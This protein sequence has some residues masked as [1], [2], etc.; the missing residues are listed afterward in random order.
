MWS[1]VHWFPSVHGDGEYRSQLLSANKK[2]FSLLQIQDGL[3]GGSSK[4][5]NLKKDQDSYSQCPVPSEKGNFVLYLKT[6]IM[7]ILKQEELF[8]EDALNLDDF[9]VMPVLDTPYRSL[10]KIILKNTLTQI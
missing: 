7:F 4:S 8:G 5:S 9:W 6:Y 10:E 2:K 3:T 1:Q